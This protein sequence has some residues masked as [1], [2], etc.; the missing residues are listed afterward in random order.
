[1]ARIFS[2]AILACALWA[3]AAAPALAEVSFEGKTIKVIVASNAGGGTDLAGRLINRFMKKYL[4]GDPRFVYQYMGAGGGKIKAANY[5]AN[6]IKPD[7]LTL[8]NTDSSPLQPHIL[9]RKVIKYDPR[10][11][12]PIGGVHRGGSVL[13]VRKDAHKRLTDKNAAKVNVGGISGAR[14]WQAMNVW[15]AEF[16]GWNLKWIV[17]YPGTG[18]LIK[19]ISQGE[20]DLLGTQNAYIINELKEAGLIDL[21]AQEGTRHAGGYSPRSSF[22]DVAIFPE[23]MAAKK[24]QQAGHGGL[25]VMD[26]ALDRGQVADAAP[27]DPAGVRQGLS[28]GVPEGRQR[29]RVSQD[30]A[31][32]VQRRLDVRIRRIPQ[33]EDPGHRRRTQRGPRLRI[34]AAQEIRRSRA[35]IHWR[36]S[37]PL[38]YAQDERLRTLCPRC[39]CSDKGLP[40]LA[41]GSNR[42]GNNPFALSPSTTLRTGPSTKLRTGLA[43]P[44]LVEGRAKS[45]GA[46]AAGCRDD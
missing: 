33:E 16:L 7:G 10:K 31:Q 9:R 44:E 21:I 32:A 23:L 40:A 27:E 22:K 3:L 36:P 37:T 17:G 19:A 34:E 5:L 2:G 15:G 35:L 45:K 43:S 8:M 46:S 30:R 26:G 14:A 18:A 41:N 13:F 29:P 12:I 39:S 1:M 11:F 24:R 6:R 4:P 25:R 28:R 20:I 42:L 38:R